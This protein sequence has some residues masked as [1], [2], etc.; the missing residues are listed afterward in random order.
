MRTEP[1]S[2][3]LVLVGVLFVAFLLFKLVRP[4]F[5][6]RAK[7]QEVRQKIADAKQRARA[8][9]SDPI[10]RAA[11]WREAAWAALR[12]LNRPSLAASYARRAERLDPNDEEAVG[13][14]AV[15]LRH[16]ARYRALER[17]LWRRLADDPN[18]Q[19]IGFLRTYDE[20]IRLY[21]GPLRRPEM[22]KALRRFRNR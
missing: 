15:S 4:S 6:S 10:R 22:A 12:G 7:R 3:I 17:F 11:A 8:R 21:D 9:G 18:Q 1:S 20:L 14:L 5:S 2:I 13:L 19:G 16:A